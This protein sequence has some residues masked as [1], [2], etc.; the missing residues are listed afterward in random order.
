[1]R[2]TGFQLRNLGMARRIFHAKPEGDGKRVVQ[3]QWTRGGKRV[4]TAIVVWQGGRQG[5]TVSAVTGGGGDSR[6]ARRVQFVPSRQVTASL[7]SRPRSR[8]RLACRRIPTSCVNSHSPIECRRTWLIRR[9]ADPLLSWFA[10]GGKSIELHRARCKESPDSRQGE[11]PKAMSAPD[12][13]VVCG[14]TGRGVRA[15]P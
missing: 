10:S 9:R 2:E 15:P 13:A 14:G 12:R 8:S 11:A 6:G 4:Q 1:M 7:L 5:N 3:D